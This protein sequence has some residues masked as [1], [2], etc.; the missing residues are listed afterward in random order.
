MCVRESKSMNHCANSGDFQ[1]EIKKRC[2]PK[3]DWLEECV[4][5]VSFHTPHPRRP[6]A[7]PS[8]SIWCATGKRQRRGKRPEGA[9]SPRSLPCVILII[10]RILTVQ[11]MVV[12]CLWWQFEDDLAHELQLSNRSFAEA[13]DTFRRA[14]V[15]HFPVPLLL[16]RPR[17][18]A[19]VPVAHFLCPLK[20]CREMRWM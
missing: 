16:P 3:V 11:A 19:F 20:H 13:S 12:D 7:R 15:P 6:I 2:G 9:P 4:S 14:E 5:E 8:C 10:L 18:S 17:F 1:A